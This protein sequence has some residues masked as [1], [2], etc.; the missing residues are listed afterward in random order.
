MRQRTGASSVV[1]LME[2]D[3]LRFL[4]VDN[5]GEAVRRAGMELFL[6]PIKDVSVPDRHFE[7]LWTSSGRELRCALSDGR[8]V[9][10]HCRG[11]LGRT[12]MIAGRLLVEL[13]EDPTSAIERVRSARP[14]A[15]QTTAQEQHVLT[16]A[17]IH[18]QPSRIG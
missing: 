9:L 16:T 10:I 5:L 4:K 11:G 1:T 6:L 13:G 3:E 18:S 14:G 12:G 17:D 7:N 8:K 2:Q 15:I